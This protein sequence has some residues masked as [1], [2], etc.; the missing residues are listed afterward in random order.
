MKKTYLTAAE[1]ARLEAVTL[2]EKQKALKELARW[3]SWQIK[4]RG[5]SLNFG[6]FSFSA[7]GGDAVQVISQECYDAL[8]GGDWHWNPN[9]SLAS[10]LIQIAKSK[11]GHIIRDWDNAGKPELMVESGLSHEEQ[12]EVEAAQQWA[13][14]ANMR[15][16]G[17]EIARNAVSGNPR[18]LAYLDAM[19]EENDYRA[20]AKRLKVSLSKVKELEEELL[21]LLENC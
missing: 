8:F 14:E 12:M 15:D 3:V 5:F 21:G 7:M 13:M 20:I 9:R 18:L 4:K 1:W 16:L 11:M 10:M 17:Y 6:P 19:Y 2:E